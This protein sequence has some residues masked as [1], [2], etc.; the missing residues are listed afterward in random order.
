[1]FWNDVNDPR[2]FTIFD[3]ETL[4]HFHVDIPYQLFYNVYYEDNN[5]KL[6]N[7]TGY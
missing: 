4:E 1:M 7:V 6:F 3:T 2:G 5:Y